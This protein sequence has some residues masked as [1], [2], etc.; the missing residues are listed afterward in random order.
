[1]EDEAPIL[2]LMT[3]H[4][5]IQKYCVSPKVVTETINKLN[6]LKTAFFLVRPCNMIS[7]RVKLNINYLIINLVILT[8]WYDVGSD[9]AQW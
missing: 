1:M 6:C 7:L 4:Q 3:E 5:K 8:W 9:G 2:I